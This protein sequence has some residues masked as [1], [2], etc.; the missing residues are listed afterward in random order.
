MVCNVYVLRDF[1]LVK[2]LS[3]LYKYLSGFWHFVS[4]VRIVICGILL[5]VKY[6]SAVQI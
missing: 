3:N 4:Q 6:E 5:A 2:L 1:I